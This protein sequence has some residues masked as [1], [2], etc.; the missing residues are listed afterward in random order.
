MS[1]NVLLALVALL[2]ANALFAAA[3]F[4]AVGARRSRIRL[5]AERGNRLA[6]RLLP[7]LED[8]RALDRYIAACQ[9]GI[10][11]SSLGL[12]AFA[13]A[14]L[15]EDFGPWLAARFGLG[16][17]AAA[18]LAAVLVLVATTA[19]QVVLGEQVPKSIAL[20]FPNRTALA[21]LLPV[22]WTRRVLRG[23]L[24]LFNGAADGVLRLLGA[25][26]VRER[27]IHSPEE[28]GRMVAESGAGG[29]L[30]AGAQRRLANAL[31]LGDRT[32]RQ[33]MVPRPRIVAID[34]A[35]PVDLALQ[36]VFDSPYTRLPVYRHSM[37]EILGVVN[38]KVLMLAL[39]ERG[40]V[41]DLK[42]VLQPV[43]FVPENL[44]ADQLITR[45]REQRA[46][47]AIVVDE[48]GG[49]AGLV[50]LQDVLASVFDEL[51]EQHGQG[52]EELGDGRVRLPGQ[53]RL[54]DAVPWLGV[55]ESERISTVGGYVTELLGQMPV[56]GD[57]V[58]AGTREF[59]VESVRDRRIGS[60]LVREVA[61]A[62]AAGGPTDG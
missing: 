29:V 25:P 13:Y 4:A 27:T 50:S 58:R 41:D 47:Q 28:I 46:Q 7:I 19:L 32:V 23:V 54:A 62:P 36:Q 40:R 9:L 22:L 60:V 49:V 48:F 16:A 52:V 35:T 38:A 45:L 17:T 37:D 53:M 55:V 20:R 11:I 24:A 8:S 51:T 14:Q 6:K 61:A 34:V 18:Q 42:Q 59:V 56:P 43:V 3:E 44:A 57:H 2:L 21:T 5:W 15:V 33:L 30:G 26:R 1:A 10:T 31:K 39:L 12:G